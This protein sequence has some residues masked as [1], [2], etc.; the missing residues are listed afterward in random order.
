MEQKLDKLEALYKI[1]E[2]ILSILDVNKLLDKVLEIIEETFG[3]DACAI[4]FYD[5]ASDELYIRAAI[6]YKT[7]Q[8]KKFRSKIGGK[9]LTG[10][11]AESKE[12]LF[13][14][15]LEE[16]PRYV[17]GVNG[18]KS[19]IAI[20]LLV[21]DKLL[22][23]LDIES[24]REYSITE[25][26]FNVLCMFANQLSQ[27]I[28]NAMTFESE[29]KKV[30]QLKVLNEIRNRISVSLEIEK[31]LKVVANS[32]VEFF[33][34]YHLLIFLYNEETQTLE[35]MAKAG[36]SEVTVDQNCEEEI[37]ESVVGKAFLENKTIINNHIEEGN[38]EQCPLENIQSEVAIPLKIEQNPIGVVFI[39]SEVSEAFDE[40]DITVLE[41]ICEQLTRIIR[42][43]SIFSKISKKSKQ[44]EV[45]HKIGQV[46]IQSFDLRKFIKEIV[47]FVQEIFGYYQISVFS[48]EEI[49][50]EIELLYYVGAP[51]QK[52]SIGEKLP[53]EKG[54]IGFVARSGKPY[55]CNDVIKENKYH[56]VLPNTKS[57]MALP[58]K[59]GMKVLGVVNIESSNLN[60]FDKSDM[61]IFRKITNQIAYTIVNAELFRQKSSA[62]N[63][64]LNLNNLGREINSTFDMQK[65]LSTVIQKL[66]HFVHCRL[67]SI[68]FYQPH[69]SKLTLMAH[70]LPHISDSISIDTSEN[71]LMNR[72]IKLRRS[73]YVKDIENELNIENK[74]KYHTKSFLNILIRHQERI[75][76]VLNLTDKLDDSYFSSQ[77]FYLINSFC[78]HLANAIVN[79]EKY[80]KIL[81][82]S[83]TDG[84]TGLYVHRFFQEALS[85]EISRARRQ[86][87]PL[88]LIMMDIDDFKAFN[89]TYGHQL[90]D[91]VLREIS[92][93][94]RKEVRKYDIPTRYGGEEFGIILPNTSLFQASM[95]AERLRKKIAEHVVT[96]ST[97]RLNATVS[98]GVCEYSAGM[99]KDD[100][101]KHADLSLMA[102]KRKGK[103]CVVNFDDE[104]I[105]DEHE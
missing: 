2:T 101:I 70:N 94:I 51:M 35:F 60:E 91:I 22:G 58:I 99:D 54:V 63:L 26:D 102:A 72:V 66:P 9:G 17:A 78:E 10:H 79:S 50:R 49:A 43:A 23:V 38:L 65:I 39:V 82:L 55:L 12:P 15:N 57:E 24:K 100:L 42:D 37:I 5:D 77:E 20:P 84:L 71:V 13:V 32:I 48:Y 34:Y 3:F 103:N 88:S 16:E 4:L 75:I 59:Y 8:I 98:L 83:I 95:I 69:E 64:L 6:G 41:A 29:R 14:P 61:E 81:E 68:F 105:M 104:L 80:Q 40:R 31:L 46:A 11:V 21:K 19:E 45:I 56:D 67:C 18:A 62:H 36:V 89:D 92:N 85:K 25:D 87:N 93:L 74:P 33:S 30:S 44:L 96:Y 90:G 52:L 73:I 7:E 27:A 76:G 86:N 1:N 97:K 47:D 53:V 28:N